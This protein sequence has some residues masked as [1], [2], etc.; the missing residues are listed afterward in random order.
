MTRLAQR[1]SF[2]PR[3]AAARLGIPIDR[4]PGDDS[5]VVLLRI[6][7][8]KTGEHS[9]AVGPAYWMHSWLAMHS[10]V[11]ELLS[12]PSTDSDS[13]VSLLDEPDLASIFSFETS[14]WPEDWLAIL[15]AVA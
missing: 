2:I 10:T 11:L 12:D 6:V 15:A 3:E 8:K 7:D 14:G 9:T 1:H 13:V 4:I 5:E